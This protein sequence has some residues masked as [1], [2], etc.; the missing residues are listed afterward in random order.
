MHLAVAILK[1]LIFERGASGMFCDYRELLKQLQ[2]TY[3]QR[4]DS[5]VMEILKPVL[6]PFSRRWCRAL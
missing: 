3:S 1:A 6:T 5:S 2:Q 4:G